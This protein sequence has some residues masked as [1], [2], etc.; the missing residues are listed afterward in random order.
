MALANKMTL[1]AS[2]PKTCTENSTPRWQEPDRRQ[3]VRPLSST[4]P[5]RDDGWKVE[6]V[7]VTWTTSD[8]KK[9]CLF[10]TFFL[11]HI[12]NDDIFFLLSLCNYYDERSVLNTI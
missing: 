3:S 8:R 6:E 12:L 10:Y 5:L 4:R 7:V 11:L 9:I 2:C 1:P